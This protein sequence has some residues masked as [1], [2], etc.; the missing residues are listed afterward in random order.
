[1]KPQRREP[2]RRITPELLDFHVRR[3]HAMRQQCFRDVW[4]AI[5]AWLVRLTRLLL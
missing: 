2:A 4:R 3:A 5:G 1:V